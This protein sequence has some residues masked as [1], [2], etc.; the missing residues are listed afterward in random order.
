MPTWNRPTPPTQFTLGHQRLHRILVGLG[1][2]VEDEVHVGKYVLDCFV[3]ELHLGFEFDGPTHRGIAAERRDRKRDVWLDKE[4]GIP[5]LHVVENELP[6]PQTEQRIV[7][8]ID[9]HAAT[10]RIRRVRGEGLE[11]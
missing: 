1:F 5:L 4:A 10:L 7:E 11:I 6:L 3:R 2:T 9:Y 8:F